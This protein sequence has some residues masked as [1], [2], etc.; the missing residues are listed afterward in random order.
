MVLTSCG[1]IGDNGH[2]SPVFS[3]DAMKRIAIVAL[4]AG[5]ALVLADGLRADEIIFKN[6]DRLTGKIETYDGAK[7]TIDTP[8]VGKQSVDLKNVRTFSSTSAIE[9]VLPDGTVLHQRAEPGPDGQVGLAAEG[10]APA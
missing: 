8:S 5:M 4:A 10:A 6:G 1:D 9:V 3:N 7:L 2:L